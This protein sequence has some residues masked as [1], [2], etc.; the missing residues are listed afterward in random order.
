VGLP[1]QPLFECTATVVFVVA[2]MAG[3]SGLTPGTAFRAGRSCAS[4]TVR[5]AA[6]LEPK[7]CTDSVI[8][9][10]KCR[11]IRGDGFGVTESG[12]TLTTPS[13]AVAKA[14]AARVAASFWGQSA[15]PAKSMA[16]RPSLDMRKV[17]PPASAR[18]TAESHAPERLM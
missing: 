15:L 14:P 11:V 12:V 13:T 6:G 8:G 5:G 9:G 18:T 7:R 10:A 4:T 16:D 17:A 1:S 3:D 2:A